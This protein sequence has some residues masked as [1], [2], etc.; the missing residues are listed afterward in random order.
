VESEPSETPVPFG[1]FRPTE[2]R[3]MIGCAFAAGC[4]L[5]MP[6]ELAGALVAFVL[7]GALGG[8]HLWRSKQER[9]AAEKAALPAPQ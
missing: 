9:A 4:I 5:L 6:Q 3:A 2:R 7:T 8:W 1:T